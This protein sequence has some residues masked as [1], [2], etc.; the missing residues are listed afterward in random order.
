MFCAK[1]PRFIEDGNIRLRPLSIFD[2]RFISN[3]LR[4]E[5]ILKANGLNKPMNLSRFSMWWWIRKTFVLAY[6]I[7]LASEP[8][9]FIGLYNLK[10]GESA[11]ISLVIFDKTFR[12]HGYG[13]RAFNLIAQ[14]MH[15]HSV[16]EKIFIKVKTDNHDALLFWRKLGFL[17]INTVDDIINIS[18]DFNNHFL[19]VKGKI[20]S[21]KDV[22]R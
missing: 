13:A 9:G 14:S 22:G 15:R 10:P 12:R 21:G 6:C 2:S 16:I 4:D 5:V 8:I 20:Y 17:K 11:E 3:G 7:E 1:T 19:F 18:V